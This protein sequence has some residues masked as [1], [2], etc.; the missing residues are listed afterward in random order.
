M[1]TSCGH[2]AV[3][4]LP[5][6]WFIP[7][8]FPRGGVLPFGSVSGQV[9]FVAAT[10]AASADADVFFSTTGRAFEASEPPKQPARISA[11][12]ATSRTRAAMPG[13]H[14]VLVLRSR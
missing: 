10:E 6:P 4:I 13:L 5:F 14:R 3:Q 8:A 12:V 2:I 11:G 7:A 9:P 1:T